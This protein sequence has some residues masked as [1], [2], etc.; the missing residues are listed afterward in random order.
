MPL[1]LQLSCINQ[2]TRKTTKLRF[3]LSLKKGVLIDSC[4]QV[5]YWA[6]TI[7]QDSEFLLFID[8]KVYNNF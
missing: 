1:V 2:R 5:L 8:L 7:E 3:V 6:D 4:L